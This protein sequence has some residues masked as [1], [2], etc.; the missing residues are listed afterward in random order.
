MD[1]TAGA[2]SGTV[3]VVGASGLVGGAVARKLLA[4]GIR[5]RA[6]SRVPTR[7]DDLAESGAEVVGGDLR[8]PDSLRAACAGI[9]T[10]F[11]TAHAFLGSGKQAPRRVDGAGNRA[12]IDAAGAADVSHF[13]FTSARTPGPF[14]AVDFFRCKLQAERYLGASGLAFTILRPT[15]FMDTWVPLIA[16][17]LLER[18]RVSLLGPADRA[19]N[20]VAAADVAAVAAQVVGAGERRNEFIEV[21]G[22]QDL[23]LV[24]VVRTI[25]RV[26]RKQC[27][28]RHAP[29]WPL[30]MLLPVLRV[31][32]PVVARS[33]HTGM[34]MSTTEQTFDPG[35]MQARFGFEPMSLEDWV[36]AQYAQSVM[37]DEPQH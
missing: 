13:V 6:L 28:L 34:L 33:L 17:P 15:V 24:Q 23:S 21:G 19:V 27:R 30:R 7:L 37:E 3:L 10:V 1:P 25:E 11:T 14:E 36:R 31:M 9:D 35:P 5:V 8:D 4:S 29:L 2:G 20:F 16:G 18:G 26:T 32:N 12:L 22:P